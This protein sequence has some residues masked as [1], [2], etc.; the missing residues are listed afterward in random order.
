MQKK[1]FIGSSNLKSRP[2]CSEDE[3]RGPSV[4]TLRSATSGLVPIHSLEGSL[5]GD[6]VAQQLQM[7]IL[8]VCNLIR[9]NLV[10]K[11]SGV[12]LD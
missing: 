1:D 4:F 9:Q 6:I 3:D 5:C 10:P 12:T 2:G 7:Y 8:A 11:S